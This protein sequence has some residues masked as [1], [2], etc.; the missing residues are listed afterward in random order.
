LNGIGRT[1]E[2]VTILGIGEGRY[3]T[4][5]MLVIRN[6]QQQRLT[7]QLNSLPFWLHCTMAENFTKKDVSNLNED[8]FVYQEGEKESLLDRLCAKL[9]KTKKR[10]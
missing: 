3:I 4:C 9:Y 10:T 5:G 7:Y 6:I 8:D 1:P 2:A